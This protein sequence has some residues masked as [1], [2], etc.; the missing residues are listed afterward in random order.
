MAQP[1]SR[2]VLAAGKTVSPTFVSRTLVGERGMTYHYQSFA[3]AL[4]WSDEDAPEGS[5]ARGSQTQRRI[6]PVEGAVDATRD[7][8][9]GTSPRASST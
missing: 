3:F 1:P 7:A 6:V 5:P 9:V 8:R 2:D 4:P